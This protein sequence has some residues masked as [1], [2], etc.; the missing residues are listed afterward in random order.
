MYSLVL[1]NDLYTATADGV[2]HIVVIGARL[3]LGVARDIDA[4]R[5]DLVES[6]R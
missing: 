6:T 2:A 3:G 1:P 5:S 4:S